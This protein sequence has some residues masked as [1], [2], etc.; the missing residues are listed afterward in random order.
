V[1]GLAAVAPLEPNDDETAAVV[2][3]CCGVV[4][5]STATTPVVSAAA[6]AVAFVIWTMRRLAAS[7]CSWD[8]RGP[9]AGG[10]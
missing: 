2:D 1:P 6:A 5:A 10:L 3:A 7:R 9:V 4:A 8:E